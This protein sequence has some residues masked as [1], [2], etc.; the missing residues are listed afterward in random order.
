[1]LGFLIQGGVV[2]VPIVALSVVAVALIV[3]KAVYFVQTRE[4]E[5]DLGAYVIAQL[6]GGR[7]SAA[8]AELE[9]KSSP[10]SR[11]L[12]EGLRARKEGQG[13]E[14]VGLRMESQAKRSA[15]ELERNVA[16]LASIAN[17]ATL[18]GLLGTVAGMIVSF[19]NLKASGVSDPAL[20]AGG[21]S[22]ALITTAAGLT[23]A[24][25][26]LLFYHVFRQRVNRTLSQVE[27]A[28]TD[29]QSYLSRQ[30]QPRPKT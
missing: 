1:M 27:I 21:I 26:C 7:A 16:Y 2:L 3:Q 8:L 29:L 24:I 11:V 6:R 30:R 14:I 10:E 19:F 22:Q 17:L 23:V 5:S 25:P 15:G 20:L 28:A 13:Q 9:T 4:S 18:L 12:L